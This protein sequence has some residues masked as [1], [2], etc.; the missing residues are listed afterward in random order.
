MSHLLKVIGNERGFAVQNVYYV[1]Y[2][3]GKVRMEGL[4]KRYTLD[5]LSPSKV[6][7]L[8]ITFRINQS[9]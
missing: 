2:K 1:H 7:V 5:L 6:E 4:R 9:I 3:A 8:N